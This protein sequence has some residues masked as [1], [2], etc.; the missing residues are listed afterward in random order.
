MCL[1]CHCTAENRGWEKCF[2]T[3]SQVKE[4]V[5]R[6]LEA[7]AASQR[8]REKHWRLRE[9]GGVDTDVSIT[10]MLF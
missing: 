7:R 4:K 3:R 8:A 10:I 1:T 5:F 6:G 2:Y 9:W